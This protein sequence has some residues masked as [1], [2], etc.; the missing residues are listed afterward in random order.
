MQFEHVYGRMIQFQAAHG[1]WFV[2]QSKDALHGIFQHVVATRSRDC[3]EL[4]TAFGATCCVMAAAV[5]EIGGGLVTTV[6]RME[7]APVG[8]VELA[9]AIGLRSYIHAAIH[10]AGYNWFLLD[11]LRER[12]TGRT[13][14]P[15]YD[16][17]F[18]DGA[19]LW[20]PDA[21]A[22]LLVVRLLRPGGW[23]L[24]DDLHWHPR[25]HPNWQTAFAHLSPSELQTRAVGQVFDLVLKPHP[26]LEHFVLS[27]EGHM[28]WCR[29]VGGLPLTRPPGRVLASALQG[30]WNMVF[31]GSAVTADSAQNHNVSLQAHGRA[32][33]IHATGTDPW[34]HLALPATS[35]PLGYVTLR[36]RLLSPDIAMTQLFW[37]SGEADHF[38]E[39]CSL[40]CLLRRSHETQ[41]L[42]FCIAGSEQA[43]PM[44]GLRLDPAD[45]AC[46]LLLESVTLGA[47]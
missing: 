7:R 4:G 33:V 36:L 18:L 24:L 9:Q 19:H 38:T 43:V 27:N 31:D 41:D 23:L 20:E 22:A 10:D 5:E 32:M 45:G 12:T 1:G 6:D 37:L 21:L 26:A 35:R 13:C 28:G 15:C 42:T 40:R 11:R 3:L 47:W 46:E 25:D 16:F 39:D 44:R 30:S 2:H 8:V 14:E 29:K 34:L 17:C